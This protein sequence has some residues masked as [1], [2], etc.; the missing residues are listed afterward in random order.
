MVGGTTK[1]EE[2]ENR[3]KLYQR[4]YANDQ[5]IEAY[6]RIRASGAKLYAQYVPADA[7]ISLDEFLR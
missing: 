7:I 2:R 4:A 6:K 3:I 5:E 1:P